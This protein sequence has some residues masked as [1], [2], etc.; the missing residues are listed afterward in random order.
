MI[1]LAVESGEGAV[2]TVSHVI[3]RVSS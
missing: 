3:A 2:L 1:L